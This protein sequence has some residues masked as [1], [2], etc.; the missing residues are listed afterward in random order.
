ML[1]GV[2]MSQPVEA[3]TISTGSPYGAYIHIGVGSNVV[4]STTIGNARASI[5][6][7]DN[8]QFPRFFMLA[9]IIEN[10]LAFG[11]ALGIETQ[12]IPHA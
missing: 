11:D 3:C 6:G 12:R 7:T 9:S 2:T 1:M 8:R 4:C 5:R 10:R